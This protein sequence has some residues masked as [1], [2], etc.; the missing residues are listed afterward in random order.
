VRDELTR[1]GL[2]RFVTVAAGLPRLTAAF[3]RLRSRV[4]GRAP[5]VRLPV[6]F[7]LKR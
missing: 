1:T 7:G 3:D 4:S 2:F 6:L 5:G